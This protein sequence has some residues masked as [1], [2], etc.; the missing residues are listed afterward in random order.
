MLTDINITVE[1]DLKTQAEEVLTEWG[2]PLE[3]ALKGFL[4]AITKLG[5]VPGEVEMQLFNEETLAAMQEADDIAS[6]KIQAKRYSSV[7]EFLADLDNEEDD[8]A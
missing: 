7:K 3:E 2:W 1:Q 4:T 8:D 6:G 5:Y